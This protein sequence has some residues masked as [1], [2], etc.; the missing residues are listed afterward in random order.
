M[1]DDF[2]DISDTEHSETPTLM[3]PAAKKIKL[4]HPTP[5]LSSSLFSQNAPSFQPSTAT[6]LNHMTTAGATTGTAGPAPP[7]ASSFA[8]ALIPVPSI[9]PTAN[10]APTSAPA[11]AP[12]HTPIPTNHSATVDS[13]TTTNVAAAAAAAPSAPTPTTAAAA[14]SASAA[15]A[16]SSSAPAPAQ[17]RT[18]A[19]A[20]GEAPPPDPHASI[21]SSVQHSIRL[22]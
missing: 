20:F 5:S 22:L 13:T 7:S 10:P 17:K 15:T 6:L 8:P 2:H 1:G 12:T 4:S 14:P 18:A 9:L 3:M 16:P 19:Q 21:V 11:P